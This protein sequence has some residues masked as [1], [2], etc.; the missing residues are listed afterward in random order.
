MSNLSRKERNFI[1]REQELVEISLQIMSEDGFAGLTMD[2]LTARSDYSKGTI[3]N[4]F[5]CKEDVLTAIGICCLNDL[6]S[7]FRRAHD[8][9]GSTR[10]R[11]IAMHFAY[12]LHSILK[13]DQFMCVLS[14]KTSTVKE[15]ASDKRQQVSM[16]R[17]SQLFELLH[18]ILIEAEQKQE[19]DMVGKANL[20]DVAFANW[21]M[22]FG[23]LSLMLRAEEAQVIKKLNLEETYLRNICITLDGLGWRPLST[24]FD[25][26]KTIARIKDE[27]FSQ[28]LDL[29]EQQGK[30]TGEV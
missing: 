4:H 19:I 17:E 24:E 26:K 11:Y 16:E 5:K 29:L 12:M 1:E 13:P 15:K 9:Q 25:Y 18:S 20:D 21:A 27:I 30:Y 22:S 2:K 23:T 8:F 10:E 6:S 7:L 3:Y 28:E 14:C